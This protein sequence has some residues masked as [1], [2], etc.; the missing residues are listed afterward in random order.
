[1]WVSKLAVVTRLPAL[2]QLFRQRRWLA[3]RAV[4]LSVQ[5]LACVRLVVA[6]TAVYLVYIWYALLLS[7]GLHVP[8]AI[9][10]VPNPWRL[11]PASSGR[12]IPFPTITFHQKKR[13]IIPYLNLTT[14]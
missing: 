1:M 10:G 11:I 13:C 9:C 7:E 12:V 6:A 14:W 8:S 5:W 2:L 3:G 4:P